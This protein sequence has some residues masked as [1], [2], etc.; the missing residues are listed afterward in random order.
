MFIFCCGLYAG[1]EGK[2]MMSPFKRP[3]E[4]ESVKPIVQYR[5]DV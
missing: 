4:P 1:G 5:G 3:V 2:D